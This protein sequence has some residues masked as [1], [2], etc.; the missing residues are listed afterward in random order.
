MPYCVHPMRK[1]EV[2]Q[3][4]E[5]DHEAFPTQWPP[6]NYRHELQNQLAHYIVARD[7]ERKTARPPEKG[8][9]GW[10]RQ[11][12]GRDHAMELPVQEYIVGFWGIW[13]MASEAHITSIAVRKEY[14]RRGIGELLL[15]GTIDLA[16]QQNARLLTLEV[17]VSN[18]SAQRLYAKYGFRETGVR[19]AY[20]TDNHEDALIMSTEDI[21]SAAY[22]AEFKALREA[23]FR[24]HNEIRQ[25]VECPG[26]QAGR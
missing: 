21:N 1:E 12:F 26:S 24:K 6:A 11:R 2:D 5:I 25:A 18:T 8:L 3:V 15:I 13:L 10:I 17:R 20:Y 7:E 22:Q 4:S 23:Y 9:V 16:F 19:K 14:Q